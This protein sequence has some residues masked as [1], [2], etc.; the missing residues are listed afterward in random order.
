MSKSTILVTVKRMLLIRQVIFIKS[1]LILQ[2]K[3]LNC[4]T[5]LDVGNLG[6]AVAAC[7]ATLNGP[8]HLQ[9]ISSQHPTATN[10]PLDENVSIHSQHNAEQ[11]YAAQHYYTHYPE[12]DGE[13]NRLSDGVYPH[14]HT[15]HKF[16]YR[17]DRHL[18][19]PPPPA[20]H[21]HFI[22]SSYSSLNH[23]Y[24]MPHS[25]EMTVVPSASAQR[26]SRSSE[27]AENA[28]YMRSTTLQGACSA[29][30]SSCGD[31]DDEEDGS[32][33]ESDEIISS[34]D[35]KRA[36]ALQ[37]PIPTLEIV[38]LPIDE[39]NERL[40]KYEL[41][42]TQLSLIRDIRRRGKNKV[43]AQ[44]CRK[45]KLDQINTLQLE[46]DSLLSQ[47]RAL[48]AERHGL[49]SAREL[50]QQR[51]SKLYR[52]ISDIPT[53]NPL[54]ELSVI[55]S[56]SGGQTTAISTSSVSITIPPSNNNNSVISSSRDS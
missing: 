30:Q 9:D 50:A 36:R 51:Y 55:Q 6:V 40:T 24:A 33:C 52:L 19:S 42:D 13:S 8:E 48:Q 54:R 43:A 27:I 39:F 22:P 26:E 44:N 21:V 29:D 53:S 16:A 2:Y 20:P 56:T 5:F 32:F 49:L 14:E 23:T 37:I 12:S 46:V 47:R 1:N 31:D 25:S 11:A 3:Y 15:S 34:R 18:T 45:R 28:R 38:N 17:D 41:T 4:K 10:L 35:E 7:M